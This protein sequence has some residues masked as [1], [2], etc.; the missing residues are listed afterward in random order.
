MQKASLRPSDAKKSCFD[1][2]VK[3]VVVDCK[4]H[5]KGRLASVVAKQLLLGVHVTVVR[6]EEL[7]VSGTIGRNAV[8]YDVFLMKKTNTNPARGP[9][10]HKSP[11][12]MFW[13]A[14]R[15]ML[16]HKNPRGQAALDRLHIFDG[17]PAPYDKM[18]KMIVP[19][20]LKTLNIRADRKTTR[21]GCLAAEVG[22]K[23]GEVV[24]KLE[25]KRKAKAQQWFDKQ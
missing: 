13:R 2:M 11:S 6:C 17:C 25:E 8:K 24:K 5:L 12:M 22:W 9:F 14:V 18:K 4:G 20:A 19:A 16:P 1:S 23:Y 10:H 15:G 3:E 21:L 7:I